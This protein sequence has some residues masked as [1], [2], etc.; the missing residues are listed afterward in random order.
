MSQYPPYIPPKDALFALWAANFSTLLTAN[1][2]LY[3]LEAADATAV[4][5]ANVVFQTA[6]PIA[7]DPDTRTVPTVAAKDVAR[8]SLEA[9]VRPLAVRISRNASVTDEA[10]AGIGVTVR[11]LVPT[12]IPVPTEQPSIALVSATSLNQTL[13]YAV[14][15]NTGKAKPFGAVGMEVYRAVGVAPTIDPRVATY[16]GAVTKSPFRQVFEAEDQGKYCTYFCR[17]VTASG[18]GGVAQR[19]PWSDALT[20]VVM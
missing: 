8:A 7:I 11:T 16:M 14:A 9:V 2:A 1:P 15:L 12:P 3:G 19:G 4:E 10:K 5:T 13:S 17:Y 18:P 6:Y 20:L